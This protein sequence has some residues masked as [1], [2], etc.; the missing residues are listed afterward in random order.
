MESIAESLQFDSSMAQLGMLLGNQQWR[1]VGIY[2]YSSEIE[3]EKEYWFNE[4]ADPSQG[5]FGNW[6]QEFV[7]YNL[8]SNPVNV[9]QIANPEQNGPTRTTFFADPN[10][11]EGTHA[12]N[13]LPISAQSLYLGPRPGL[14]G[15]E[16][17]P[18]RPGLQ[19]PDPGHVRASTSCWWP[20]IRR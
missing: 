15:G 5:N 14:P 16:L 17:G 7:E 20:P 13:W 19:H 11:A 1:D 6:P 2:L 3:A 12:I 10:Y 9:T 18:V 4:N 8:N